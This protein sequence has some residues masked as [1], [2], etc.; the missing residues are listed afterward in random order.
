MSKTPI[1]SLAEALHARLTDGALPGELEGFDDTARAAAARFVAEAAATRALGMP[2]VALETGL[3]DDSRA[4]RLAV[5]ND[6]MP[7][8]VDSIAA[9]IAAH[10]IAI[11]RIIHPVVAVERAGDGTLAGIGSGGSRE[12]M[13]Y[14]ELERADA[15]DR[16][17]LVR[18]L[19]RNLAHVRAAVT[20]WTE[21]RR[22][23]SDDANR[24][25]RCGRV[26]RC[27]AGSRVAA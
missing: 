1:K 17:G 10:D 20:D 6:D 5:V 18:D 14:L 2:G 11:R 22:S 21:L 3:G 25:R 24:I 12:S 7:F 23:M 27:C 15:R 16:T 4:M 26:P 19:E 9:T 8:L 13:I